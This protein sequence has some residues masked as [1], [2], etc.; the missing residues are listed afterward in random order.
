[1]IDVLFCVRL[2]ANLGTAF[3]SKKQIFKIRKKIITDTEDKKNNNDC[4][5][6]N[7]IENEINETE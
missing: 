7:E 4:S 6:Y 3:L 2:K 5:C 1:M